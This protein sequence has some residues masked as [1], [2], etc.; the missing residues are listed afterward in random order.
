MKPE[1]QAAVD[2]IKSLPHQDEEYMGDH[3]ATG[4]CQRCLAEIALGVR[5]P[6]YGGLSPEQNRRIKEQCIADAIS[7]SIA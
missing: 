5:D 2:L 6:N 4:R 3:W 7:D 1:V